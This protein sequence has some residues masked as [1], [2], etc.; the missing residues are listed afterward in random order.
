MS[1]NIVRIVVK[2]NIDHY[3]LQEYNKSIGENYLDQSSHRSLQNLIV[4]SLF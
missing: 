2:K 3:N 4:A 1:N